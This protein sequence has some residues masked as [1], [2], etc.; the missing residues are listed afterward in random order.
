MEVD[1]ANDWLNGKLGVKGPFAVRLEVDRSVVGRLNEAGETVFD[2][3]LRLWL[4]QCNN[5]VLCDNI[6]GTFF[7]DTRIE[8]DYS[9][10]PASLPMIQRFSLKGG[11]GEDH[12]KFTRFFFGFTGAAGA[13]VLNATISRFQLSFIRPGDSVVTDDSINWP[14]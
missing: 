14:P 9:A 1:D 11:L 12:D 5:D 2:Y 13:E 6:L 7:Q 10:V 8:Y 3:E 4:R